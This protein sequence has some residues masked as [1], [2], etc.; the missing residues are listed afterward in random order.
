[1]ELGYDVNNDCSALPAFVATNTLLVLTFVI[2]SA[3]RCIQFVMTVR[4][5]KFAGILPTNMQR[6]T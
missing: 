5:A 6:E 4:H 2:V 1:M 3:N